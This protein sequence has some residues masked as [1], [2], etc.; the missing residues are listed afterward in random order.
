MQELFFFFYIYSSFLARSSK[1]TVECTMMSAREVPTG[2]DRI[3]QVELGF[4][5][6][7]NALEA[8]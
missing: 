5:S 4:A 1:I 3:T 8:M 2:I 7:F 6:V